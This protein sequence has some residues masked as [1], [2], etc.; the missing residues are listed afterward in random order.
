VKELRD[1]RWHDAHH[2]I[3][4]AKSFHRYRKVAGDP[5]EISTSF[6]E[7]QN[8]TIRMQHAASRG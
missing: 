4:R 8:L 2:A 7:R 1:A 3:L 6:I 5:R